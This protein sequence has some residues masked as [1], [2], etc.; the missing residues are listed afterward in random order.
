MEDDTLRTMNN[1]A[2]NNASKNTDLEIF[3]AML[4][5]LLLVGPAWW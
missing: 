1:I 4:P 2:E 5:A 3:Q